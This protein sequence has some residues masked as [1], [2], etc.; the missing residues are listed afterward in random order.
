[1]GFERIQCRIAASRRESRHNR[2]FPGIAG[3]TGGTADKPVGTVWFGWCVQGQTHSECVRFTGDRA[4]G[5]RATVR[6]A[7]QRF[8][9]L[10]G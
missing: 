9:E 10:L 6:H 4:A 3:P 7:L 2:R 5:R 1:M 8:A